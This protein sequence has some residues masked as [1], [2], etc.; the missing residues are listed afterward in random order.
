MSCR[1]QKNIPYHVSTL[2]LC[3]GCKI[4]GLLNQVERGKTQAA[5]TDLNIIVLFMQLQQK[6]CV[7]SAG[8]MRLWPANLCMSLLKAHAHTHIY[9]YLCIYVIS[10]VLA[11]QSS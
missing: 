8:N 5:S 7:F 4:V 3:C 11:I 9:V 6:D 10:G 2:F 1:T